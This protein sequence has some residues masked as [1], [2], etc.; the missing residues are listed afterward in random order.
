MDVLFYTVLSAALVAGTI[1][2][3]KWPPSRIPRRRPSIE[4]RACA[5]QPS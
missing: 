4:L 1:T 3:L 5:T 2:L